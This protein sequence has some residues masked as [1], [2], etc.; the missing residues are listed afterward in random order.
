MRSLLNRFRQPSLF[1]K[2]FVIMVVSTIAVAVMTS[3]VTVRMSQ[4]LFMDTFSITNSKVIR[5]IQTSFESFH[6]AII[7][8]TFDITQSGT[9]KNFLV[10]GDSNSL[11]NAGAFYG[12][13]DQM[14][15]IQSSLD[16]YGVG[17]IILGVNGRSYS[18]DRSYWNRSM[19]ELKNSPLTK[20]MLSE[21]G[22]LSYHYLGGG[23]TP[24]I[25]A[26][27]TL[28]EPESKQIYGTLYM[29]V[30]E[31]SF[32]QFYN[33]FTSTGNDVLILNRDGMVVSSNRDELIGTKSTLLLDNA[34]AMN[35]D[36]LDYKSLKYSGKD[37][38]M[39]SNYLSSYDF[40]IVNLID[41]KMAMGR[42]LPTRE[43]ILIGAC[44]VSAALLILLLITRRL[45]LSLRMLVR[46]MSSVAKKNFD[47]YL[48]V[49]GSYETRQLGQGFNYM[50][51]E[52]NDYISQLVET[53]KER[54][55]AELAALQ[56][57][58]NPHFLYNTLASVNIL[59]Q[60]GSKEK[61]TETIHALISLLQNTISNVSETITVEQELANMK[62][63]VF[64]NQVRYGDEIKVDYFVSQDC[65]EAQLPKLI[66]Q[67]FIENAFFHAFNVKDKGYIYILIARENEALICEVVDTGDGMDLDQD[68]E[69]LPN[70][71]SRRQ[72]FTGIGI[73]NVDERI[74]LLYGEH[75]GVSITSKLG[76]GTK[77]KIKLPW[78]VNRALD[79]DN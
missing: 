32:R 51:G 11:G 72:L 77:V 23:S 53:Q 28:R 4:Q 62:D 34:H 33:S 5:Q 45:T 56:R 24:L 18:N 49:N 13:K 64:I 8:A 20:E 9:I 52:L 43:I 63:Y 27:K 36:K 54:R 31:S 30:R 25:A 6:Y 26:T 58:I 37:V 44:I 41:K 47:N 7:M 60:R 75:Y 50:L 65:M 19:Q 57:Q 21:P 29:M 39:L 79:E 68:A 67:P 61:A 69:R 35:Q 46:Q 1:G 17:T 15:Q 48:P 70:S 10:Q 78:L 3:W 22:R 12:M 38:V 71:K 55:N 40:Y 14:K 76:E 74:H 59:V 66:I 16:P 73:R 42:M 2:I